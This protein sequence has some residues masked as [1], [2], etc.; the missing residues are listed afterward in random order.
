MRTVFMAISVAVLL[1]TDA[2][3][4]LA[5]EAGAGFFPAPSPPWHL[6]FDGHEPEPVAIHASWL[7]AFVPGSATD[8]WQP[9]R[10]E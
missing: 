7:P 2:A 6:S 9:D 8:D 1:A 3:P 4:A 5:A 10:T